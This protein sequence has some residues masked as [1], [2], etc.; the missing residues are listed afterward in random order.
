[1]PVGFGTRVKLPDS[2][3]YRSITSG[4]VPVI[5]AEVPL[6]AHAMPTR[7]VSEGAPG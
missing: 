6:G 3:E 7:L 1:M 2:D 4:F 5:T